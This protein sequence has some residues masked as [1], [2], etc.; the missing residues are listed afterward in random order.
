MASEASSPPASRGSRSV[1]GG[2]SG[3]A[4]RRSIAA[5]ATSSPAASASE[6]QAVGARRG[7]LGARQ[8]S[9]SRARPPVAGDGAGDVE[10]AAGAGRASGSSRK[11]STIASARPTLTRNTHGQPGPAAIRP[12]STQPSAP[13]PAAAAVHRPSARARRPLGRRGRQQRERGGARR[14]GAQALHARA[15]HEQPRRLGEPARQRGGAEDRE[16]R[17]QHAARPEQVR[18]AAHQHQEAAEHQGVRADDPGQ[19]GL[20]EPEVAA[21]RRQRDGDDGRV[22][23]DDELR[24]AQERD[25]G[26]PN[27]FGYHSR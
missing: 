17:D 4:A 13:P 21:D 1:P 15:P 12:P 23:H 27:G 26:S 6:P 22:E 7:L 19:R 24:R 3:S 14:R 9:T 2:S 20:G 5:N 16:P 8:P 11:A 25:G 18:G 10:R